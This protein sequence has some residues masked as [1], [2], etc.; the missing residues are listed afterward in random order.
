MYKRL[1][2]RIISGIV[3]D[4]TLVYAFILVAIILLGSS[5]VFAAD[6]E[7]K[8]VYQVQSILLNYCEDCWLELPPDYLKSDISLSV[9]TNREKDLFKALQAASKSIGW[10]LTRQGKKM[11]ATPVQNEGNVVYISC[12]DLQPRN[13]PK[14]LYSAS[15]ESDRLQCSRRDSIQ[16]VET[17]RT[18]AAR[19]SARHYRDSL[20]KIPP[21]DYRNY[22]LR[23]YSYSKSFTDK[24]GVEWGDRLADGNLHSRFKIYDGWK[25][26]ANETN[27]TTFNYRSMF[28]SV[29]SA[30]NVDWGSEEQVLQ[31]TFVND[32]VMTT[33]YEWRKY[34]II[35]TITRKRGRVTMQYTFRDKDNSV[36]VLQ[37]SVVGSDSDTLFLQGNYMAKR[38]ISSGVPIL[39][40][41][42]IIQYF[43]T[44][45]EVVN[46][47][48]EF[49]L[50]LIP[51][52]QKNIDT[53]K[54]RSIE[55]IEPIYQ[56]K[57]NEKDSTNLASNDSSRSM[58]D[59][60]IQG[61]E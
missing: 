1:V 12:M 21:L 16:A 15:I 27:D 38:E 37:G 41:I 61:L 25:L 24:L 28:F 29:D 20:E 48:K 32:G 59:D 22:E 47:I 11:T 2:R 52:E 36:S 50:Y 17:A 35:V 6:Y 58:Q 49:E 30:L 4:K 43:F 34:G 13:V 56:E 60:S 33:D 40:Q 55:T 7:Y 3:K 42:P 18:E 5:K 31:K 19:D 45:T 26:Y 14:Y 54:A 10:E 39:C 8:G 57:N 9:T 51:Q 23:Y 44:K 53:L 46:D